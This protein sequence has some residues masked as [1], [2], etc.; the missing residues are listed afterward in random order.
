MSDNPL[1]LES[2]AVRVVPYD[3]RWAAIAAAEIARI[4]AVLDD[5]GLS[6]TIEHTGSTAVPGLDAKPVID[7]LA[8][9]AAEMNRANVIAAIESAGYLYRGEQGLPGRDFFRRGDPRQYHLHL[10]QIESDFWREH[11]AFRD[12]LRANPG[13][14]SEYA[15]LKR[16]LAAQFPRD[17]EKYIDGKAE[18]VHAT[19]ARIAGGGSASPARK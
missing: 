8:G 1:G 3:T 5:R 6:L 4:S 14:A 2:G 7:L 17:R 9:Q 11:R 15:S 10:T 16:R 12:H 18:F 13:A 19:L